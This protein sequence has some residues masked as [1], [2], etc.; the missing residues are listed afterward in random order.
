VSARAARPA[1]ALA[2]SG[3]ALLLCALVPPARAEPPPPALGDAVVRDAR[4]ALVPL[5]GVAR[6]HR[7]TVIV[8]YSATCPCFD[9][10]R[11]RLRQLAA[12]LGPRGVG[13]VLVDS[14]RRAAGDPPPPPAAAGDLPIFRDDGGA[15]ARRLGARYATESYVVDA[16]G[17][18]RYRGGIDSDRKYL[19][20]DAQPYLRAAL[21]RLL[22]GN[23][24]PFTT[25][26]A[27][28]CALRLK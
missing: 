2:A 5:A 10:H 9:A 19:R 6:A 12:E 11:A 24:P 25:S 1:S 18:A 3:L 4:G 7:F 27:L 14:E 8:F 23:A 16:A 28:G 20:D 15:L 22:A 26:K 21:D 13:V 17:Q